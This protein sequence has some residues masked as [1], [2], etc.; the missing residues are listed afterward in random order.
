M[1]EREGGSNTTYLFTPHCF[2]LRFTAEFKTEK[3]SSIFFKISRPPFFSKERKIFH[4]ENS[5]LPN[6]EAGRKLSRI[7]EKSSSFVVNSQ[8]LFSLFGPLAHLV[9]H[10]FCIQEATGS[11]PVR[12]KIKKSPRAR[13]PGGLGLHV[14]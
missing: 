14:A 9:E 6:A 1:C 7:L 4:F 10:L 13:G 11:I 8:Y 12:S 3:F 2:R 5:A